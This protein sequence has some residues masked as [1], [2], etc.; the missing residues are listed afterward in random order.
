VPGVLDE[1]GQRSYEDEEEHVHGDRFSRE[2]ERVDYLYTRYV[3]PEIDAITPTIDRLIAAK[4]I[5]PVADPR[6]TLGL[7]T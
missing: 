3:K 5:A 6:R 4:R 2:S 1:C 7:I